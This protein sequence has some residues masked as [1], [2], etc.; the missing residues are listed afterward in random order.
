MVVFDLY[1]KRRNKNLP[2]SGTKAVLTERILSGTRDEG[3][4]PLDRSTSTV[5]RVL[6]KT[7]FMVPF[8]SIA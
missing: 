2:V 7:W 5:V 1:V 3:N 8:T 4:E 6:M